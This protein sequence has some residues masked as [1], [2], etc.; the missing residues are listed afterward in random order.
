M[1]AVKLVSPQN[2][3]AVDYSKCRFSKET[4]L[5]VEDGEADPAANPE[6]NC[7]AEEEKS[8]EKTFIE[9]FEENRSLSP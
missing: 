2:P 5:W 6:N 4:N 7:V 1:V 3:D 9:M 8:D